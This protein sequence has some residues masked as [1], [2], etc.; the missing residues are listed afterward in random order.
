[1][2]YTYRVSIWDDDLI[3]F[4]TVATSLKPMALRPIYRGLLALG[5][6]REQIIVEVEDPATG[7]LV[8]EIARRT[9]ETLWV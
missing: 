6:E 8:S 4:F 9:A 2:R 5:Y 3:D 1:M 7:L